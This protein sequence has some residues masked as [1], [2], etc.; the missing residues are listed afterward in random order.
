MNKEILV[1]IEE[2]GV[3]LEDT[4]HLSE[5]PI[6]PEIVTTL[7]D[8]GFA[9]APVLDGKQ[10]VGIVAT[11]HLKELV[12]EGK[13]LSL[14]D[15]QVDTDH[16]F[17]FSDAVSLETLLALMSQKRAVVIVQLL[18]KLEL[19]LGLL[20]IS[21]LNRHAVRRSL[22]ELISEVETRL[23]TLIEMHF[24]D[25]HDWL[26]LLNESGQMGLLGHWHYM[27]LGGIEIS[28]IAGAT[29]THLI[30]VC[31]KSAEIRQQLEY[32][33]MQFKKATGSIPKLRNKVMHPVRPLI[34]SHEEVAE[35]LKTTE[36]LLQLRDKTRRALE[37]KGAKSK[38]DNGS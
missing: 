18:P 2:L 13:P 34:Y 27:K 25:S 32:S 3:P 33:R 5:G 37:A 8:H 23:A 28:M 16:V 38:R 30:Q 21:D 36:N 12:A 35:V 17:R 22:Y 20:T 1:A 14:E 10:C 15:P 7:E 24:D 6:I 9:Q 26:Q 4:I 31:Q 19:P 11:S 29:I